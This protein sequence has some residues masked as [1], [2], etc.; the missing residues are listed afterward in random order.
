[1]NSRMLNHAGL[2][3]KSF[4]KILINLRDWIAK[5]RPAHTGA[6]V[7]RDYASSH[8]YEPD[9]VIARQ[10]FVTG[11]V[12]RNRLH[13]IWDIGCNTGDYSVAALKGG[14][15][16][17]VGFDFD[18]GALELAFARATEDRLNF[19]LLFLDIANPT[20]SQ[21]WAQR[22]RHGLR[23]RAT[24]DGVIALALIHHLSIARNV[25]L[26]Q[27][28]NWIIGLAPHGVLEFVP[29][30]DPMI[31]ELLQLRQDIFPEYTQDNFLACVRS[32]AK[33]ERSVT[34]SSTGRLLVEF[35]RI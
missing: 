32:L 15:E 25:P 3:L 5:L 10:K 8:S 29:K 17:A 6:T 23:G 35:S 27:A 20:P 11:F 13:Q 14:A 22:E 26:P 28:V 4:C 1:M 19:T 9:E 7:W 16:Y 30:Q 33:I 18:Q 24:A 2:P 34:S 12:R 21:G 31:Q